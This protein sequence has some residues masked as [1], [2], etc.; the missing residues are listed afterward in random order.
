M[1]LNKPEY[2]YNPRQIVNRIFYRYYK[3]RKSYCRINLP[4][5]TPI[6]VNI[7]ETIGRCLFTQGIYDLSISEIIFRITEP[8]DLCVDA[9]ANIGYISNLMSYK[10]GHQG[11]VFAFEPH[12]AI[13]KQLIS[14]IGLLKQR[15]IQS[16]NTALSDKKGQAKL[17]IPTVF[18]INQGTARIIHSD[19]QN[20]Q[21]DLI[22]VAMERLDDIL[23]I[24]PIKLL[25][26]DVE[27]YELNV[28]KGAEKLLKEKCI[29]F[30]IYED[31]TK[32]PGKVSDYLEDFGFKIYKIGKTFRGPV[33]TNPQDN[34]YDL[35]YEPHNYLAVSSA[36][37]R[38]IDP[39]QSGWTIYQSR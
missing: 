36:E 26:I 1:L 29:R 39:L 31:D 27:G 2:F 14:N 20:D 3:N 11:K 13:Y 4:W 30:I 28:L 5:G 15:N 37:A 22:E 23:D 33:L 18:A 32:Y 6:E 17:F 12:P 19:T 16:M 34:S 38:L 25:K 21:A 9:G 7:N 24:Q 35:A 10:C 8:G